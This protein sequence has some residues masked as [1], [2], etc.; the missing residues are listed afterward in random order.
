[1]FAVS[2]AETEPAEVQEEGTLPEPD[3]SET[4]VPEETAPAEQPDPFT[5]SQQSGEGQN[6]NDP[7][8]DWPFAFWW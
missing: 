2:E 3:P 7:Y 4:A 8:A 5:E 6:S 1:M